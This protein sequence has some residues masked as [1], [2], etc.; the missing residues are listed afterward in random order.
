M[1]GKIGRAIS[2]EKERAKY[3]TGFKFTKRITGHDYS[4]ATDNSD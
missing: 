1:D 4:I 3:I 2:R